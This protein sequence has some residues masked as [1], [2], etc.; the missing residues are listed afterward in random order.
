MVSLTIDGKQIEVAEGTTVLRAAEAA[1]V[2]IPTLCDHPKVTPYGGCRLCMVEVQGFRGPVA[3]CTLPASSGMVVTTDSP[4]LRN[5]RKFVLTLLFSER[6]H[7]CPFCQLSGGDCELQNAAYHE[8]MTHWP[9]QPN[10]TPFTVDSSH[11][12]FVLDNNRCILCRRC[13]RA[14]G[15]L[16]GNFTLGIAERGARSMLVA[17]YDVPLGESSCVACGS[18]LQVCPTGALIDRQ[19]AYQGKEIHVE[20]TLSTCVGCSVGCG[21]DVQTRD[22]RLVRIE[23]NWDAPVNGGV[24]CKQ[25]RFLAQ[26]ETAR[27]RLTQPLVRRNGALEPASWQE[28][29]DAVASHVGGGQVAALASTRLSA[30][31]LAMFKNLFAALGS[32]MVT[33]VEE[34]RPTALAASLAEDLGGPFEGSLQDLQ[35]A[36]CVTALGVDL[37]NSHQVA[38]FMIKRNLPKGVRLVVIDPHENELDDLSACSLK[39]T[40]GSDLDILLALQAAVVKQGLSSEAIPELDAPAALAAVTEKTG[41]PLEMVMRAAF[42]MASA[43][44]PVI[45]YGKGISAAGDDATLKALLELARLINARVLSPK[46]EANSVA[47]SQMGLDRTF[48]LNGQRAAYIALGDD[49]PNKRLIERLEGAPFLAVQASYESALTEKA[50]VVLPVEIWA[51]TSGHY[52]NLEGRIQEVNAS[53][54]A[55]A[56]VRSN[57]AVFESLAGCLGVAADCDWKEMLSQRAPVVA[58]REG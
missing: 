30:E 47:A 35:D 1:G 13:V 25:G 40:R 2:F 5:S 57:L 3:S 29:L 8:D 49:H 31:S 19:S 33:S 58:I 39:A 6:N 45:V 41:L 15:E 23:G 12:Y 52:V 16:A 37:W 18:C 24:L 55:P 28:A 53:L 11:P 20:H 44:R 46:G 38:G 4:K 54:T 17:D 10:W 56:E 50:D 21:I 34:G 51:E 7:F 32:D 14:C 42:L 26:T 22:N 27:P 48:K 43:D 36:D 9:I